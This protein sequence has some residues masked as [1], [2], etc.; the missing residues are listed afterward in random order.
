MRNIK[1]IIE[2][3]GSRYCGWQRQKGETTIQQVLEDTLE[4]LCGEKVQLTGSGRTDSGVHARGQTANFHTRSKIPPDRFSYALNTLLPRDIR[5]IS[6]EEAGADFHARFSAKAKKY[7]YSI[8]NNRH[9][10][11]IGWQYYYHVPMH[12]DIEAM[13]KAV[14]HF[15][16]THDFAAF[17]AAGSPVKSTVRT[18]YEAKMVREGDFIHFF[19]T[20]DGFLYNMVRIM[21]GTLIDVGKGKISP[22]SI[23]GIILS[24]DRTQA[25]PT[26]PPHGL[27]LE[28][29]YY[30]NIPVRDG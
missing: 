3:D 11:A 21:A 6:S 12:L 30:E 20:G 16:G 23:P 10:T 26:A 25:G 4:K 27:T 28:E 8:V 22:D 14:K 1:L 19:F 13:E 5:I 2:Y 9:G 29:V 15:E 24:R 7:R 17:M 18:I